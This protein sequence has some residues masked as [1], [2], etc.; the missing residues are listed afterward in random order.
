MP[1]INRNTNAKPAPEQ[2]KP[3]KIVSGTPNLTE[4]DEAKAREL[5]ERYSLGP[6][7]IE[8][9]YTRARALQEFANDRPFLSRFRGRNVTVWAY[10]PESPDP[11]PW[12]EGV[13]V[14]AHDTGLMYAADGTLVFRPWS[15]IAF[16]TFEPEQ[17]IADEMYD[18]IIREMQR[19]REPEVSRAEEERRRW[20]S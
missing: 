9:V 4:A 8:I 6:D 16:L 7:D 14:E 3:R 2:P 11:E 12:D 1:K 5:A 15:Q 17:D 20:L 10:I 13:A 19:Q 18:D